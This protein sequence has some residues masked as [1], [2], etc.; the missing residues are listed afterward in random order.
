M[1]SKKVWIYLGATFLGAAVI[2]YFSY[3]AFCPHSKLKGKANKVDKEGE[4]IVPSKTFKRSELRK[5]DGSDASKPI[6][7]G[8]NGLV[9]DVS[10]S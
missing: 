9:F 10:S 2:T 3:K 6:Y 8:C 7:L 5:Y 1:E 4:V